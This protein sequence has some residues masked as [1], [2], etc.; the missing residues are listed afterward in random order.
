MNALRSVARALRPA[1]WVVLAFVVYLGLRAARAYAGT[2]ELDAG[3][4][5]PRLDIVCAALTVIAIQAALRYRALPWPP[6]SAFVKPHWILLPFTLAPGLLQLLALANPA[7]WNSNALGS[8]G[9]VHG[10]F[11]ALW[12][13]RRLAFAGLPLLLCWL[14]LGSHL[15]R[16]GRLQPLLL[17]RESI[18]GALAAT[19]DWAPPLLM[20][21][22]YGSLGAALDFNRRPDVDTQLFAIDQAIFFGH[23]PVHALQAITTPWLSDWMA[24]CYSFYALLYAVGLGAAY[25]QSREGFW[26]LAL[27]VTATLAIGYTSF[28]FFPAQGPAFTQHFTVSLDDYYLQWVKD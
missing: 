20:L 11:A 21:L 12:I 9:A 8:V 17:G 10:V 25:G 1:E 5:E 19:R 14:A 4:G 3:A 6:E 23:S 18:G 28:S 22:A 24:F 13:F 27:A 16:H 2:G 7:A 15:K 26:T